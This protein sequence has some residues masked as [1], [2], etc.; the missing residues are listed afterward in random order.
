M[1]ARI[2]C[3]A[4]PADSVPPPPDAPASGRPQ[5]SNY[6]RPFGESGPRRSCSTCCHAVGWDSVHVFCQR[7]RIVSVYPCGH[8]EREAGCD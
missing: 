8:W 2:A 5:Q 7:A 3:M 6:F 4:L 1:R